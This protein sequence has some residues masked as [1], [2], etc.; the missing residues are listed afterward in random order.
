MRLLERLFLRTRATN[1]KMVLT[2]RQ[3]GDLHAAIRSYLEAQGGFASTLAAFESEDPAAAG[4]AG[5]AARSKNLLERKWTSVVRLQRKVMALEAKLKQTEEDLRIARKGGGIGG[6][7]GVGGGEVHGENG[8]DGA[9]AASMVTRRGVP[10]GPAKQTMQGHRGTVTCVVL[11]PKFEL[12]VSASEDATIKVWDYESGEFERTLKGHTNAVNDVAFDAA[13]DVLASCSSDLSIKLWDFR[14]TYA[15]RK[16]LMGHEH[17]VSGVC[18]VPGT[19][20]HLV[21][22]SRDG[23]VRMWEVQTGYCIHTIEAHGSDWVRAIDVS[24]DGSFLASCSND[25]TAKVWAIDKAGPSSA[26]VRE[27]SVMRGHDHVIE[28]VAFSN[29]AADKVLVRK[30]RA[31]AGGGGGQGVLAAAIRAKDGGGGGGG[32]DDGGLAASGPGGEGK[33][34]GVAKKNRAGGEFLVT[35]SRD[36][37]VRVWNVKT[38]S[39]V[40]TFRDHENWVRATLFHPAGHC[41]VSAAEDRT[42]RAFDLDEGRCSRTVS[43]A[44]SH[45]LTCMALHRS[46][47]L[48]LTGGVDKEIRSWGVR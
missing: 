46:G 45:F 1:L 18:F 38:G 40:L 47:G 19:S 30:A 3:R 31:A 11:H 37:S 9:A 4:S 36:R 41:I 20:G 8:F 42:I 6:V 10:R 34:A 26:S 21:S 23:S 13:G 2:D 7:G 33:Q 27:V 39:C 35:G 43:D 29:A 12:A 28:S 32:G 25:R 44:H 17:T 15:C 24:P 22:C 5:S 16:T 48:L 14:E